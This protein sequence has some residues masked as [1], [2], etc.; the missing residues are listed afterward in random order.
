[1]EMKNVSQLTDKELEHFAKQIE[2]E[3][4]KRKANNVKLFKNLIND[5]D[6]LINELI[7]YGFGDCLAIDY[8]DGNDQWTWAEV[9][10]WLVTEYRKKEG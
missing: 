4:A 7:G 2:E 3:K 6:R 8:V 5:I 1:M 9:A 10:D